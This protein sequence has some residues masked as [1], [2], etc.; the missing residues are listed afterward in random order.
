M[1]IKYNLSKNKKLAYGKSSLSSSVLVIASL[2]FLG[3][4]I[5][6]LLVKDKQLQKDKEKLNFYNSKLNEMSEKSYNYGKEIKKIGSKWRIKVK[7]SNSLISRKAFSLIERLNVIE[8]LLPFGVYIKD[9]SMKVEPRGNVQLTIVA[10]SYA[11]LFQVYKRFSKFD[12]AIRNEIESEGIYQARISLNL[13]LG[14]KKNEK[15]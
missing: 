12:P 1:S 10:N 5:N 6:N 14:P 7:F 15:K 13:K 11:S 3:M 9:I 8:D 2:L 4:G